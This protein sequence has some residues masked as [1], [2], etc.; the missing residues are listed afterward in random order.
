[1]PAEY[2]RVKREVNKSAVLQAYKQDGELVPGV[3]IER[4]TRLVIR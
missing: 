3:R 2:L 4:A 1:V